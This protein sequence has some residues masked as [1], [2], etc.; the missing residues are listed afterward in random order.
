MSG[1]VTVPGDGGPA[2]TGP[3]GTGDVLNLASQIEALLSTVQGAGN[4]GTRSFSGTSGPIPVPVTAPVA[5]LNLD[6]NGGLIATIPDGYGYVVDNN[7]SSDTLTGSAVTNTVLLTSSLGGSYSVSG[8]S[9]VAAS[10]GNNVIVATGTYLISTGTGNNTI[11][12]AGS[13]TIADDTG[14]NVIFASGPTNM[15]SSIGQ[16]TVVGGVGSATVNSS[17]SRSVI[18]GSGTGNGLLF[19]AVSGSNTTVATFDSDASITV[20]GSQD[21]VYGSQALSNLIVSGPNDTLVGGTG[22]ETVTSS[23]NTLM[24][25]GTG[26]INFVGGTGSATIVG[27]DSGT[28]QVT[29]GSGWPAVFGG[30]R[31]YF[32]SYW[33]CWNNNGIWR[34]KQHR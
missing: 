9:T 18:F 10:A 23:S 3:F 4:L 25:G 13:G 31:E 8:N 21:L 6:G 12:A 16:D 5:L 17:G 29:V 11:S 26:S 14:A 30:H 34:H 7:L 22:A 2:A 19:T 27:A 28:E 15:I 1:S 32:D 33:W 20:S 24:F